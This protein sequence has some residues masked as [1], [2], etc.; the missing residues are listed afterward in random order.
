M[1]LFVLYNNDKLEAFENFNVR[2]IESNKSSKSL[3]V[4]EL[5]VNN[6]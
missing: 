5:N 1:Q 4:K 2:H 6:E 3:I